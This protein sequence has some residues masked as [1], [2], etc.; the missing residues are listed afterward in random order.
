M[1]ESF[2]N[3][4]VA[5]ASL[6]YLTQ[7]VWLTLKLCALVIPLGIVGGLALALSFTAGGR[8]VR[9]PLIVWV[10]FFRAFQQYR[11]PSRLRV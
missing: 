8:A 1:I 4:D 6:P 3:P 7:G 2:F 9:W 11:S 10:D 5:K